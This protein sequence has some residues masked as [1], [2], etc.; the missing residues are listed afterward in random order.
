VGRLERGEGYKKIKRSTWGS[1]TRSHGKNALGLKNRGV[2]IGRQDGVS[3]GRKR[4]GKSR[5]LQY[6]N[7][8]GEGISRM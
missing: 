3:G 6:R 5:T 4:I 2:S 7:H 8:W 1:K